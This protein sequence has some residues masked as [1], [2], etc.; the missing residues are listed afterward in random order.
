MHIQKDKD[1]FVELRAQGWSL[2]HIAT[3]LHISKRTMVEWNREFAGEIKSLR[4][5]EQELLKEKFL[6]TREEELTLLGRLQKDIDDEVANRTL[7]FVPIDKLCRLAS[8]LRHEIRQ[9]RQEEKPSSAVECPAA[10]LDV[11]L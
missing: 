3:E 5:M 9:L 6:A 10:P 7:K 4:A 2:A 1:K 8:D 11:K